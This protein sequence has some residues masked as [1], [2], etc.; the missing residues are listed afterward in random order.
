[1]RD[2][3]YAKEYPLAADVLEFRIWPIPTLDTLRSPQRPRIFFLF[4]FFLL[5]DLIAYFLAQCPYLGAQTRRIF[6]SDAIRD[7]Q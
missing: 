2:Q 7:A 4:T 1:M 6:S 3:P 5:A